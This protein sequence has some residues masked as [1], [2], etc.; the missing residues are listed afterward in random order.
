MI[1][2]V[3]TNNDYTIESVLNEY[4]SSFNDILIESSFNTDIIYEAKGNNTI[5]SKISDFL[6]RIHSII[7]KVFTNIK[8]VIVKVIDIIRNK[9]LKLKSKSSNAIKSDPKDVELFDDSVYNSIDSIIAKILNIN[10]SEMYDIFNYEKYRNVPFKIKD[11]EK[12]IDKLASAVDNKSSMKTVTM[13][14]EDTIEYLKNGRVSKL[15]GIMKKMVDSIAD[16]NDKLE[17][18]LDSFG[19]K[20]YSYDELH[21]IDESKDDFI[22]FARSANKLYTETMDKLMSVALKVSKHDINATNVF[23]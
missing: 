1:Y 14:M 10:I 17:K 11:I 23:L 8:S 7:V 12:D 6:K 5:L 22:D 9:I 13:T 4:T 2:R 16:S 21:K 3:C 18:Y 19:S 15:S 20:E